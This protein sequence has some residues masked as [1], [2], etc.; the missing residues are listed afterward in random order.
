[1]NLKNYSWLLAILWQCNMIAAPL[2]DSRPQ[3]IAETISN[4]DSSIKAELADAQLY[5]LEQKAS[6]KILEQQL[7]QEQQRRKSLVQKAQTLSLFGIQFDTSAYV[8]VSSVAIWVLLVSSLVLAFRT[9]FA[10]QESDRSR[11]SLSDIEE[12]FDE[13]IHKAH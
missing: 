4:E 9:R 12:E 5:L 8:K 1:M 6:I 11:Q 10:L 3:P 2:Q 13:H 7:L